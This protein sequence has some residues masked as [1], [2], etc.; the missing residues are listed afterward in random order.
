M[1][2][3]PA[4]LDSPG[5][6]LQIILLTVNKIYYFF[7]E[8]WRLL[9][10][11]DATAWNVH[12]NPNCTVWFLKYQCRGVKKVL[13][14]EIY[15]LVKWVELLQETKRNFNF[16]RLLS[17]MK[18]VPAFLP[19]SF[20]QTLNNTLHEFLRKCCNQIVHRN[21]E[22]KDGRQKEWSNTNIS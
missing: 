11:C 7:C 5:I 18:S 15:F 9:Q 12:C 1:V 21:E 17:Y 2:P 8:F 3:A 22:A 19:I 16:K 4:T 14:R 20:L 6:Y 10:S 13:L